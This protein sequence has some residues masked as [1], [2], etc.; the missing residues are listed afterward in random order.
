MRFITLLVIGLPVI[1]PMAFAQNLSL[2]APVITAL[3]RAKVPV[4][5][6]HV[7]VMEANGSPKTSALLSHQA[8]TSINP[9]SLSKLATTV[10]A[11]DLLGPTYVIN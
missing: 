6:L 2:P 5:A 9:A 8:N 7:V 10:A 3:Q 1:L 11:L 4:E